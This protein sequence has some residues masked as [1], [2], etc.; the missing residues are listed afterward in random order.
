MRLIRYVLKSE[1]FVFIS[2]LSPQ[3]DKINYVTGKDMDACPILD[4]RTVSITPKNTQLLRLSSRRKSH[5]DC[6]RMKATQCQ[7]SLNRQL[8]YSSTFLFLFDFIFHS[9]FF[10]MDGFSELN[11]QIN[12]KNVDFK[13]LVNEFASINMYLGLREL[14]CL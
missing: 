6:R 13:D 1:Y 5:Y 12:G 14:R 8:I 9:Q 4:Q 2:L 11:L 10:R 3:N 7:T